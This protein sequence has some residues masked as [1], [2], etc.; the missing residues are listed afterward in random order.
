MRANQPMGLTA[1]SH[2]LTKDLVRI[3]SG[4]TYEGYWDESF[5]LSAYVRP[6]PT[7]VGLLA[8]QAALSARLAETGAAIEAEAKRLIAAG[9]MAY[10]EFEQ[11][12]LYSSGPCMFLA[13]RDG[14]GNPVAESL[15]AEC[16]MAEAADGEC[17][18]GGAECRPDC[19]YG[20]VRVVQED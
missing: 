6:G 15:W 16:Q 10:A 14:A 3:D 8:D 20:C 4:A 13:L 1:E 5:P 7:L 19:A 12:T 9:E 11:A 17:R 18:C 2:D